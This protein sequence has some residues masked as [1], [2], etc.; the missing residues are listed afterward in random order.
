MTLRMPALRFRVDSLTQSAPQSYTSVFVFL[1]RRSRVDGRPEPGKYR[2][3]C[4]IIFLQ[5][6]SLEF[7]DDDDLLYLDET[8]SQPYFK[9]IIIVIC[10]GSAFSRCFRFHW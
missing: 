9:I 7:E 8:V 5:V 4:Y 1:R 2:F 10:S 6:L 3:D